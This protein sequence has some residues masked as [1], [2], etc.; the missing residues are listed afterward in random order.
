V[1]LKVFRDTWL[2]IKVGLTIWLPPVVVVTSVE[3]VV[4]EIVSETAPVVSSEICDGDLVCD[5]VFC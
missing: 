5:R 4:W 3:Y 2:V 1:E